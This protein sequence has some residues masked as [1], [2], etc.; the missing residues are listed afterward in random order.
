MNDDEKIFETI[1]EC[2]VL[3]ADKKKKTKVFTLQI[4]YYQ[5]LLYQH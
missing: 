4:N 5:T 3:L 1:N 2:K